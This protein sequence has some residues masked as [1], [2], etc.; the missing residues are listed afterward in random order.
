MSVPANRS[1]TAFYVY[2]IIYDQEVFGLFATREEAERS[3]RKQIKDGGPAWDDC[4]IA[5]WRIDGIP[6]IEDGA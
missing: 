2:A 5:R 3:L 6:E 1:Q 4:E